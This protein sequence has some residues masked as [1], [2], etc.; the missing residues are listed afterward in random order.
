VHRLQW[1]DVVRIE[2][3]EPP[4]RRECATGVI[5][6]LVVE[7]RQGAQELATDE[8]VVARTDAVL[9]ALGQVLPRAERPGEPL[10]LCARLTI[11]GIDVERRLDGAEAVGAVAATLLPELGRVA[12]DVDLLVTLGREAEL[13][14]VQAHELPPVVAPLVERREDL[15]DAGFVI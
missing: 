5:E 11:P 15:D 1:L 13:L 14:L 2:L 10:E 12:Q 7:L 3:R 9:V 4:E 6:P 8:R